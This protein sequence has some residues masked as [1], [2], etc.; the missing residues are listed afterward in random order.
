ML[1]KRSEQD[2]VLQIF[3]K[4][5]KETGW[6]IGFVYKDLKEKWGWNEV[7]PSPQQFAQTH[8]AARQQREAQEAAEQQAA[9]E[10]AAAAAAAQQRQLQE[11]ALAAQRHHQQ[12]GYDFNRQSMNQPMPSQQHAPPQPLL[13]PPTT[14]QPSPAPSGTGGAGGSQG[15]GNQ[16]SGSGGGGGGGGGAGRKM[17]QGIPNP[18]YAKA[19]FNLPQH[20]YQN[21]YVAPNHVSS[22]GAWGAQMY[23]NI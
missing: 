21:F 2:E 23:Y 22:G 5:N 3:E 1:T 4:I 7:E 14:M 17:P 13:P 15:G 20:P 19:D 11:Q 9:Q 12:Q 6:R 18:M 10:E 8:T 16:G